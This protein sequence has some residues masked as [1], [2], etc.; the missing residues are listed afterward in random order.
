M[1]K[2]RVL[3]VDDSAVIRRILVSVLSADPDVEVVG[4]AGDGRAALAKVAELKPDVMTLDL[5]MPVLD[6]LGTLTELRKIDR[7]LPVIVFSTLSQRGAMATLD[8]L[9]KGANDYVTKPSNDGDTT[10]TMERIKS[11]L[12]QKVKVLAGRERP[13][14]LV[15]SKTTAGTPNPIVRAHTPPARIDVLAIGVS[16][17]GPNALAV[18]LPALAADFPVPVVLVQ[19][20]PPTFTQ[21]LA[22]H[23]NQKCK[24]RVSEGIDGQPLEAGHIYI[25]PGD[26]HMLVERIG[27]S[28]K[29]K[30]NQGAPENFCRPAV[31]VLFRSVAEV[32]GPNALG[33]VLT[34][35]GQ[36]GLVGC[37]ALAQ[38]GARCLTQ[39]EATSVVWGMPGFVTRAGLAD[40][41]LPIGALAAEISARAQLG[42]S[43]APAKRPA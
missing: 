40:K 16:T 43:A 9:A 7:R 10:R 13:V 5:E 26:H 42:R 28:I 25:A 36:D 8:A 34:G 41:T 23:L 20:M 18:L 2:V 24:L 39:D 12:V 4:Q 11:E 6:G 33:V 14:P 32:Y 15:L 29:L 19:H 37:R 17:G 1:A 22:Q 3:V 35:M 31:D 38:K 21:Y 30:L 27:Q